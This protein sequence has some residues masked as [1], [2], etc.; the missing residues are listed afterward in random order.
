MSDLT[1]IEMET[2]SNIDKDELARLL[3]SL[4]RARS[5]CSDGGL[6]NG[7]APG[8]TREAIA[9]VARLFDEEG[10]AYEI[11]AQRE[12]QPSLLARVSGR[13]EETL[14][15]HAHVDT[16]SAGDQDG[17]RHDPFAGVVESGRIYGRGA[18][19]DKASVVA[20]IGAVLAL[21]RSGAPLQGNLQLAVVAD[22]ETGGL[23]GT[24]WLHD[25]G[26]LAP[27]ALV[28]GEQTDNRVAIAERV[29]CGIDLTVFGKS[30]H[31]AMPW[32][33]ENAVLK[34][35]RVLPWLWARLTP[36]FEARS[37]DHPFLPPPTLN[38]GKIHG[39][40]Q[41]NIVPE[42]CV[43]EMDRRLVP[44]ETRKMAMAELEALLTEYGETVEALHFEL[45]STGEV[46]DNIN[47]PVDHSFVSLAQEILATVTAR[48][49][50]LTGYPHSSDGRWF[51]A[52]DIPIIIFGPGDPA[53]AHAADEY[54][55]LEQL[56]T[57]TR[58]LTLLALRW[59]S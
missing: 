13:G 9:F 47:T 29:A 19:D 25:S 17:W 28:V 38:V 35:A 39:G 14:L 23:V 50:A 20:Q 32:A 34:T 42:R 4:V 44:G 5:D 16:V 30:A 46:A 45:F 36:T 11:V 55:S 8:D 58:F 26:K 22:E 41:W 24:K 49:V 56:H 2:L 15:F 12:E 57:A 7:L 33:G 1:T 3:R 40:V 51:A 52:D 59:R 43:V 10:I 48:E 27:D 18:G 54:V 53:L 6:S 31:G 21:A 37:Q